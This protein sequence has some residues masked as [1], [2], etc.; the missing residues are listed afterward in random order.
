MGNKLSKDR[1]SLLVCANAAGEKEKLLV[2]GKSKRPHSF[3]KYNSNLKQHVTYRSNKCGW[4]TMP[5]FTEFLNSLYNKMQRQGHHIIMFL[6]NCSSHPHLELSNIKLVFYPKN[7]TSHLQAMDQ[8]VI[9]NL[10]KNYTKRTLNVARIKA[11]KAQSVTDII[12]EI[13]IFDAILHTKVAWEAIDPQCIIKCFDQSSIT[14][15]TT[16]LPSPPSS[17]N[18]DEHDPEFSRYFK[19]LLDILWD[20]YLAMDK[21]LELEQPARAPD[22]QAYSIEDW[23]QQPNETC[24][25]TP[26]IS[27][28]EALES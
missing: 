2:I 24:P 27:H 9:A 11:K 8:G 20:E 10:K 14:D 7:T 26:P 22:A 1:F 25:E 15:N 6:N 21:E 18:N 19:E 23:D 4:M 13:R 5:I 28:T 16:Q 3:P 12:K 17:P